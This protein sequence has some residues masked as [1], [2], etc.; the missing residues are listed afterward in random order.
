MSSSLLMTWQR[1][2]QQK[3]KFKKVWI[4]YPIH[5]TGYDLTI[6]IKKTEVVYQPAP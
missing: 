1:K 2:L 5:V 6:S 4:K 3:R